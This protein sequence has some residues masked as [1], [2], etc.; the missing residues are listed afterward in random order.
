MLEMKRPEYGDWTWKSHPGSN[1]SQSTFLSRPLR[2]KDI[3]RQSDTYR[4]ELSND[5]QILKFVLAYFDGT[6]STQEIAGQLVESF[7]KRFPNHDQAIRYVQLQI[8][9]FSD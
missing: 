2:A 1:K 9:L 5:G 4:P 7:P 3:H 8:R 6:K